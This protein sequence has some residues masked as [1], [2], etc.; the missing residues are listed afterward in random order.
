MVIIKNS[1]M[2]GKKSLHCR[3]LSSRFSFCFN[4]G[5]KPRKPYRLHRELCSVSQKLIFPGAIAEKEAWVTG[6]FLHGISSIWPADPAFPPKWRN[7]GHS[8]GSIAWWSVG[9]SILFPC[10]YDDRLCACWNIRSKAFN[11]STIMPP[12]LPRRQPELDMYF[13]IDWY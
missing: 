1:F 4:K 5:I 8:K 3:C 7:P 10:C 12:C 6:C 9:K 13:I 11:S 2:A